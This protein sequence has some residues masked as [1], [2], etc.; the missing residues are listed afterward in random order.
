M[1]RCRHLHR[2]IIFRQCMLA[3]GGLHPPTTTTTS[4][5]LQAPESQSAFVGAQ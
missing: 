4:L 5:D 3:L 1:L 2:N